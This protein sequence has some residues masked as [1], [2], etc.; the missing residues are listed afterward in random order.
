MK[1]VGHN[2]MEHHIIKQARVYL[3][4]YPSNKKLKKKQKNKK[5]ACLL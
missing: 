1:Y 3:A 2:P 4:N 5:Q